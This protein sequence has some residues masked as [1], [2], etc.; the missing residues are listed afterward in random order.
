MK[1]GAW[2]AAR[3]L[4]LN[5]GAFGAAP[6]HTPHHAMA[7]PFFTSVLAGTSWR[8]PRAFIWPRRRAWRVDRPHSFSLSPA[9]RTVPSSAKWGEPHAREDPPAPVASISA[10]AAPQRY[11]RRVGAEREGGA[12]AP[13]FISGARHIGRRPRHQPSPLTLL[14]PFAA[15]PP[16]RPASSASSPATRTPSPKPTSPPTPGPARPT[17]RASPSPGSTCAQRPRARSGRQPRRPRRRPSRKRP[18]R[19]CRRAV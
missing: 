10:D 13:R 18:P 15:P 6:P 9:T 19:P 14:R 12:R 4:F 5:F 11:E 16:P 1:V 17:T 3:P 2:H 8:R 7:A